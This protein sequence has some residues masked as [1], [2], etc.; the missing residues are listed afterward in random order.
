VTDGIGKM[1][2]THYFLKRNSL[3]NFFVKLCASEK[4]VI[5][6]PLINEFFSKIFF[7]L[8]SQSTL[9]KI[10]DFEYFRSVKDITKAFYTH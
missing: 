9:Q 10:N 2:V 1:E 5:V 3:G 8:K 6:Q 4:N 7:G